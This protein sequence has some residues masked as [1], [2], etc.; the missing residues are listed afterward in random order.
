MSIG[1]KLLI[2]LPVCLLVT[3]L[4]G[5]AIEKA[6]EAFPPPLAEADVVSREVDDAN[7][8]LLRAFATPDGLWRL[9]TTVD[10]VDPQFLKMLIA[11][12]DQRFEEHSGVDI[13]AL[14][15]A[16]LQFVSNGRIV[17]GAST[18]SMQVARLIEP[19]QQR[20][21]TAK[22]LQIARAIQI[23]RRL[24]KDQILNLYLTHA[25]YGGNIEV[26]APRASRG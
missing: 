26:C 17:S 4:T 2:A 3:G 7:G 24:S 8:Q 6:D 15:R 1:R 11:Y 12:E 18:L 22:M 14:G 10:D 16:A 19:R 20:S 5:F 9:K 25:P 23:E 21:I 13:L